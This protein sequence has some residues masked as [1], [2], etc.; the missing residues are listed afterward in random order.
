MSNVASVSTDTHSEP[1]ASSAS[2]RLNR[3][4]AGVLGAND[5]IIVPRRASWSAMHW[6]SPAAASAAPGGAPQ[7]RPV[8]G[9]VAGGA[10]VL[11]ATYLIGHQVGATVA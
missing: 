1:N 11:G 5:G 10:L 6:P 2:S 7:A 3:L 9:N 8:T 4:R